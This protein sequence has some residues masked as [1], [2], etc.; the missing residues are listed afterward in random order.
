MTSGERN[1]Y[2]QVGDQVHGPMSFLDVREKAASGEIEPS[3][4]TRAGMKNGVER[5]T[6]TSSRSSFHRRA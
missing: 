2:Y 6:S 1:W 4:L 5:I 3:T